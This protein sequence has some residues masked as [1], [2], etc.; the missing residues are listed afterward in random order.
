MK[1]LYLFKI[2][3]LNTVILANLDLCLLKTDISLLELIIIN[4]IVS[5]TFLYLYNKKNNF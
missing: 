4:I 1:K 3:L 5:I 2:F